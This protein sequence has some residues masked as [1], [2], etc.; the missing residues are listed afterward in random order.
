MKNIKFLLGVFAFDN[1]ITAILPDLY[2]GMDVVSRELVG[3]IPSVTRN[4]SAERAAKGQSVVYHVTP[5]GNVSDIVPAM[6]V[7]EPTDQTI[8]AG[9]IKITKARAAEFGWTGEEMKGL[10]TGPGALSVQA[11][12]FAQGLRALVNEIEDDLANEA[13]LAASRMHGVAGTTPFASSHAETAQLKKILDDNGAPQSERS[14]VINTAAG[15]NLRSLNNLTRV[16]EAGTSMTL[17]DGELLNLNQFSMKESNGIVVPDVG[18]GDSA[19]TN[20]AGYAVGDTEITLASTGTGSIQIGDVISFAGDTNQYVVKSGDGNVSGGGSITLNAPGLRVAIPATATAI[21]VKAAGARNIAFTRS[22]LHLVARAP[23][24]PNGRDSAIDRYMLTD[25]RSG[26]A[27]EISIYEGY[28]KLRAEV[29]LAWGVKA[30]KE[31][32][33]AG[34][35][36]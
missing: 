16:N 18:T 5:A 10:N 17:R 30:S 33:I 20:N 36:G 35:F 4:V 23:A 6:T 11:D 29:G 26:L 28:K 3:F 25:P 24:L 1:V 31:E 27:F 8:G 9:E 12:Q 32:H 22:A 15:A 7:P 34:L 13:A 2:A 14:L 19:T 21:T